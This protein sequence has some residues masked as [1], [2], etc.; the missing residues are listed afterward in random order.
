MRKVCASAAEE[1]AT[2]LS[3]A[4][5]PVKLLR[6]VVSSPFCRR[7]RGSPRAEAQRRTSW[8]L[9][10]HAA[11]NQHEILRFAQDDNGFRFS[12]HFLKT[13]IQAFVEGVGVEHVRPGA[14]QLLVG[15]QIEVDVE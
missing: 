9:D 2:T 4:A 6:I 5:T 7:A 1:T 11:R 8:H 12:T 3:K 15:Q 10:E 13:H 14:L